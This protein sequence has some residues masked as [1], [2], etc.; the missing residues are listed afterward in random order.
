MSQTTTL[1]KVKEITC[2]TEGFVDLYLSNGTKRTLPLGPGRLLSRMCNNEL[3]LNALALDSETKDWMREQITAYLVP[4]GL[5]QE[6]GNPYSGRFRASRDARTSM[7]QV[8]ESQGPGYSACID[9]LQEGTMAGKRPCVTY[10]TLMDSCQAP[11]SSMAGKRPSK[12][13]TALKDSYE[14]LDAPMAEKRPD[15]MSNLFGPDSRYVTGLLENTVQ[16]AVTA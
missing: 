1:G 9:G 14:I 7:C 11:G 16:E 4:N 13:N 8:Y 5:A 15:R 12:K 3:D 2:P 6:L 10:T